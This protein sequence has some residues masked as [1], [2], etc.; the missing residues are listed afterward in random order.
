M[1]EIWVIIENPF[2]LFAIYIYILT[3]LFD[4]VEWKHFWEIIDS[5][6]W[7]DNSVIKNRVL[8]R[9]MRE[10]WSLRW[11]ALWQLTRHAISCLK[12]D[13]LAFWVS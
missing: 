12:K 4:E 10:I 6:E 7:L 1:I 5:G 9:E 11:E 13:R 2:S 3:S 8:R